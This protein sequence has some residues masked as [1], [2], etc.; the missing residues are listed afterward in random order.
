MKLYFVDVT[1]KGEEV[2]RYTKSLIKFIEQVKD[3]GGILSKSKFTGLAA[4]GKKMQEGAD[5]ALKIM[6]LL[7]D[8]SKPA[9][10]PDTP[11]PENTLEPGNPMDLKSG[12]KKP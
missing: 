10:K 6:V 11:T 8:E 9:D 4:A 5:E 3:R 1:D 2:T 7:D 12:K